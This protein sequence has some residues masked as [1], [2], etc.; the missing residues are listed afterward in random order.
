MKLKDLGLTPKLEKVT[1]TTDL[2][3]EAYGEPLEFWMWDRQDL[4]TFI[5]IASIKEDKYE[6]I[7]VL[8]DLILDEDGSPV[9]GEG[10]V[11]PMPILL[12]V[13]EEVI[14]KVGNSNPLTIAS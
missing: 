6:I 11:L 14:N 9:L 5:K 1:V 10:D 13:A 2:I 12:A 8:K 4:P 7:N 3:V